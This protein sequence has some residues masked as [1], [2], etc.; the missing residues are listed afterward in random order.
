MYKH[1]TTH[2]TLSRLAALLAVLALLAAMAL[3]VYAEALDGATGTAQAEIGDTI[4]NGTVTTE[5]DSTTSEEKEAAE[6]NT[7]N[8]D[9]DDAVDS[10][11]NTDED[12][13]NSD[14][15]EEDTPTSDTESNSA[16]LEDESKPEADSDESEDAEE[17]EEADTLE[18]DFALYSDATIADY[19]NFDI[20]FLLPA[21][22][23]R[24]TEIFFEA[25]KSNNNGENSY[26][27]GSA[28][29]NGIQKTGKMSTDGRPLYKITIKNKDQTQCPNGGYKEFKVWMQD[30]D[31]R[32][33]LGKKQNDTEFWLSAEQLANEVID[34]GCIAN[35]QQISWENA[36]QLSGFLTPISE[37]KYGHTLYAGQAM[38]F[39]NESGAELKNVEAV[40]YDKETDRA[41]LKEV[42]RISLG[43]IAAG[44][45]SASFKIP[46]ESCA[47]IQFW[48]GDVSLSV[49]YNFYGESNAENHFVYNAATAC[50]FV[51]YNNESTKGWTGGTVKSIYFDATYSKLSYAG[52]KDNYAASM[53]SAEQKLYCYFADESGSST[54]TYE[55]RQL[56]G[57]KDIWYIDVPGGCTK[58]RFA[59]W[60]VKSD[61]NTVDLSGASTDLLD[62]PTGYNEPC[63]V[64][65]TNDNTIN[66]GNRGGYWTEKEGLFHDAEAARGK[67]IVDIKEVPFVK[68]SS[69]K[70]ITST[71][72]DYYSDWELNGNNRDSY[73][74]NFTVSQL[75]WVPFRQFDQAISDYYTNSGSSIKY[76][77]Y[78]GHFQPDEF[79]GNEKFSSIAGTLKLYGW[80]DNYLTFMAA[81]NS[82]L[83][84]TRGEKKYSYAF[85]GIVGKTLVD[86]N[87]VMNG[88]NGATNLVEPH[89]NEDFLTKTNSKN[90]KL[91]EVY[92]DVA[93]PFTKAE[94]FSDEQGV[95]YWWFD[96]AKTSLYLRKD[97]SKLYLG[98]NGQGT[99][100]ETTDDRSCNVDSASK[101]YDKD[102]KKT[103][104]TDY[105]FFPFNE[106]AT[107][108]NANTYN[109]GYGAK[110]EIPFTLTSDG[111]VKDKDNK[112]VP[113]RFYFSGDDD[114]WVFIDNQLV[115][116][117][118][119]A[120]GKVSGVLEFDQKEGN[121]A[122]KI[123]SYVSQVKYNEDS[124][125]FGSST[126]NSVKNITYTPLSNNENYYKA[127]TVEIPNLY[128]GEHTL[129]MYYMERGMWESNMAVA[130]NFPDS[131]ELQVQKIV[132]DKNV[133]KL[134]AGCFDNQ[135]FFNFTIRNQATHYGTVDTKTDNVSTI[136]LL[137]PKKSNSEQKD[138]T[139]TA[140]PATT[141]T[142]S[143]NIFE[144]VKNPPGES[145]GESETP[146]LKWYAKFKDL[147]PEPGS[148]KED[149]YGKLELNK[150]ID[151]TGMSYLSF[152]IYVDSTKGD[153]AL[154]N[155]YLQLRDSRG[156]P[157]G[158]LD[159]TFIGGKMLYGQVEMHNRQWITVKLSLDDMQEQG[160]F[161]WKNVKELL[162]GCNYPREIYL[163]NIVFSAKAVPTKITG[164]TTKQDTI[165]DYGS[166]KTGT[167][168]PAANAQY[169]SDA[170][171]GTMVVDKNGGFVL[172]NKEMVTFKDQFRRGSYLSINEQ[173]DTNLFDTQWT[174]YEDG[175]PVKST[176]AGQKLT[177]ENNKSLSLEN[178]LGTAPDDGR[179]ELTNAESDAAQEGNKY[180][181][182]KPSTKNQDDKTIVFRSYA[183]PDATEAD[184]ETQLRVVFVNKVKTGSLTIVKK[185][186]QDSADLKEPYHFKVRFTNVGGHALGDKK[187]TWEFDLAAG[188]SK[189]LEG[190][191]VGTRFT[192]EEEAPKDGSKLVDV[193]IKGGNE[194]KVMSNNT[195][196]GSISGTD[197]EQATVTFT[198][199]MQET[200]DITGTKQWRNAD[201]SLMTEH[202]A[203]IYVQLQRRPV[204]ETPE[205]PWTPVTYRDETYTKVEQ[206]HDGMNFSFLGLPAKEYDNGSQ[207]RY[208]YRVVE[209]SVDKNVFHAVENG[210]T[211]TIDEK[212]YCVTYN[213][214]T[215]S[216]PDDSSNN[217]EQTVTITNTQQDPK[218]AL[219]VTK[220]SAESDGE[221]GQQKLLAGVEFTLEKMKD[222][223]T[224]KLVVDGNFNKL[225]GVT[226]AQG[227]LMLKD[228]ADNET[229][230]F[231][232]LE[233]GTYRLTETKAAKDYNLLSE[234][235]TIIFSKDGQCQVGNETPR[236]AEAGT[237]FTGD[238][239][240]GYTLALTVLNRKTPALPHTGADAPSLWLLIGLP[241]AVAGLLILVFRY[242]KKGGRTR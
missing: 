70:Y 21:S 149:R 66:G 204:D 190:I 212:V 210:K 221:N 162:F 43:D 236:H 224:G 163:R 213:P 196:R 96:S 55:L 144:I 198:N 25:V 26:R 60:E 50:Y 89:F 59:A 150:P 207:T 219:D 176:T 14:N 153:A 223:D 53:P 152:D 237:I 215:V 148:H 91:G 62:I 165:A 1:S 16:E 230:G 98:N 24:G 27:V 209:G 202:P 104:S 35:N 227:V 186:A 108:K 172:Q 36:I 184:G 19:T 173:V 188:A 118:G 82:H 95:N 157:K 73:P 121:A 201:N 232:N 125:D 69:T 3:P 4:S 235:I 93:F 208:E 197:T 51:Y 120:H 193:S 192:I 61:S 57:A 101:T 231:K 46:T 11:E 28:S 42:S 234:P 169:T 113:I 143:G 220:K 155:M 2:R 38:R 164:F 181:G 122:N 77:I 146:L 92:H 226:N 105:G 241:L 106:T 200:L 194:L 78:T 5:N 75:S 85:Q 99:T 8:A 168:M 29:E 71:L 205:L 229:Q 233:A 203:A 216:K 214:V 206:D 142:D 45:T 139:A 74:G 117:I 20:Y 238:A 218:F 225:T 189:E 156:N 83:D 185:Q 180:D 30:V 18:S 114:V 49:Q 154:S 183:N 145:V 171:K 39:R 133:N 72:Y 86:G 131:N 195:V 56:L 141:T 48:S 134:F 52:T 159:K 177:L 90:A 217:A 123:T 160:N 102:G 87:P 13:T 34:L 22:W 126:K 15:D 67:D 88:K 44:T 179:I 199:S 242:N 84:A 81:N 68:S 40:F 170:E 239:A 64:A 127:S 112:S 124:D 119:G 135:R 65:N 174:I 151:I 166:A 211:I 240:T 130:F 94:I 107:S 178:K 158:C 161:D 175:M 32:S 136:N 111:T 37:F 23:T 228:S 47:Y 140:K 10:G 9:E 132:D 54:K 80:E 17:N 109:Y 182:K 110:L 100:A 97:G 128:T 41:E 79:G 129:T 12:V 7:A 187:I 31:S 103:V 115:L 116:D 63:F 191:P 147:E 167:L 58:V 76:P 222:D 138:F 137:E 6:G 33:I